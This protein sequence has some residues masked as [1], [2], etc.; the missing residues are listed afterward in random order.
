MTSTFTHDF[1]SE[2][3][4]GKVSF[5]TGLFINGEWRAGGDKTTIEYAYIEPFTLR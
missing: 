4:T 2:L 3:F 5:P 1:K